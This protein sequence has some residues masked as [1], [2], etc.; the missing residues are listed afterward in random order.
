[1]QIAICD[2]NAAEATRLQ[3]LVDSQNNSGTDT[4]EVFTSPLELL[5]RM[6]EQH[7]YDAILL[8]VLMP[9]FNGMETA[10]EI[11]T[12]DGAV[13]LIFVTSSP[14]FAVE[15]YAV[16]AYYYLLKPVTE[17]SLFPVLSKL[18]STLEGERTRCI[19]VRDKTGVVRV[20]LD[21][22]EYIEVINKTVYYHL[23][24]G[25]TL[26]GAGHIKALE[27]QLAAHEEFFRP[28]R[29]YLVNMRY[30]KTFGT[31][32]MVLRSGKC[33]PIPKAKAAGIKKIYFQFA[34]R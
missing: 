4:C 9:G 17:K 23:T 6:A 30:V 19:L 14:E 21:E 8:D 22:L 11:R 32:Q 27:A 25:S 7:R 34:E 28:H 33:I 18:R 31:E 15:S 24:S 2:D 16:E 13:K 1:M 10:R 5:A 12:F 3:G 20:S 26:E 29:S